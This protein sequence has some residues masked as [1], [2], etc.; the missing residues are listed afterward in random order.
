MNYREEIETALHRD[1]KQ[2]GTVWKGETEG[3]SES[4]IKRIWNIY[5]SCSTGKKSRRPQGR[6]SAGPKDA[7]L[8]P[9]ER[10]EPD[11]SRGNSKKGGTMYLGLNLSFSPR[12]NGLKTSTA[13]PIDVPDRPIL[14]GEL[15]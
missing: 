2:Y 15:P 12:Q 9:K 1:G 7:R 3:I 10:S 5:T 8:C 4:D 13:A 6:R 14:L 11:N